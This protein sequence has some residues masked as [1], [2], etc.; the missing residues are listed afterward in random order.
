MDGDDK[1]LKDIFRES[2]KPK[3]RNMN[4][5]E[6][7]K[8]KLN[9][10]DEQDSGMYILT[11]ITNLKRSKIKNPMNTQKYAR[12]SNHVF[13][14]DVKASYD[15]PTKEEMSMNAEAIKEKEEDVFDFVKG[16]EDAR[17]SGQMSICS[18]LIK[19][20]VA[21]A[22]NNAN[23]KSCIIEK[24]Y[25]TNDLSH[26]ESLCVP[27][28]ID[29]CL[30]DNNVDFI[31]S[32][33]VRVEV[34]SDIIQKDY[35]ETCKRIPSSPCPKFDDPF[36]PKIVKDGFLPE[37]LTN[38]F[39]AGNVEKIISKGPSHRRVEDEDDVSET[40]ENQNLITDEFQQDAKQISGG[41]LSH[42]SV[43]SHPIYDDNVKKHLAVFKG[44]SNNVFFIASSVDHIW[45]EKSKIYYVI[46]ESAPALCFIVQAATCPLDI[47][48]EFSIFFWEQEHGKVFKDAIFI[49][50]KSAEDSTCCEVQKE[51]NINEYPTRS[52]FI[53]TNQPIPIDLKRHS[54]FLWSCKMCG[55]GTSYR[56][57]CLKHILKD[58][59]N[60]EFLFSDNPA[61]IN[62][63]HEKTKLKGRAWAEPSDEAKLHPLMVFR[64]CSFDEPFVD[65]GAATS[66]E[67]ST[68]EHIEDEHE[69]NSTSVLISDTMKMSCLKTRIPHKSRSVEDN[70]EVIVLD[71]DESN[72]ISCMLCDMIIELSGLSM[73]LADVHDS[74]IS[75]ESYCQKY[76]I[77]LDASTVETQTSKERSTCRSSKRLAH[78][79]TK[80]RYCVDDEKNDLSDESSSSFDPKDE[81]EDDDSDS[82]QSDASSKLNSRSQ[83]S[84]KEKPT[85]SKE[86][87]P[88]SDYEGGA[89]SPIESIRKN[90]QRQRREIMTE[91]LAGV[92]LSEHYIPD[93]E[94]ESYERLLLLAKVQQDSSKMCH[95]KNKIPFEKK[96]MM[97]EGFVL[98]GPDAKFQA[99][100]VPDKRNAFRRLLGLMQKKINEITPEKLPNGRI[101]IKYFVDFREDY[102]VYPFNVLDVISGMGS[103]SSKEKAYFAYL[104]FLDQ[105]I[106]YAES[107]E[108]LQKFMKPRGE[109][110][111][112][113]LSKRE[114]EGRKMIKEYVINIE[115]LKSRMARSNPTKIWCAERLSNKSI[116]S[117]GRKR[118]ENVTIPDPKIVVPKYVDSE[119]SRSLEK[120]ML[121]YAANSEQI[122]EYKTLEEF[123]DH[124]LIRYDI[125][126]H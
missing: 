95:L 22:V 43:S 4:V 99:K 75:L 117:E 100:T 39:N 44:R 23:S 102:W 112:W 28:P 21:E 50:R 24:G 18:S 32:E 61:P 55:H 33:E 69:K 20:L 80:V 54:G 3:S 109:E 86:K 65:V 14:G 6:R 97:E 84:I 115:M 123:T 5:K 108:G 46:N 30:P 48:Y 59:N 82:S 88:D 79:G 77:Y 101:K 31:N 27:K 25:R 17:E 42:S 118:F 73:H 70:D 103:T 36:I 15:A 119:Y 121:L 66:S 35:V 105:L 13:A 10:C 58:K 74:I 49:C 124:M 19:D 45:R 9:F 34:T 47:I 1:S 7:V 76:G 85:V 11:D 72:C 8:T 107:L 52:T 67:V 81:G 126:N 125:K 60:H 41:I 91:K 92:H 104:T 71:Q 56:M 12:A 38:T 37:G 83:H 96:K 120:E 51:R 63:G 93:E 16:N 64:N 111:N 94:D 68:R 116:V 2:Y 113:D 106:I 26:Y 40:S 110:V 57:N 78:L 98:V 114:E 53:V 122:I 89:D 87:Y 90:N 62:W 29:K